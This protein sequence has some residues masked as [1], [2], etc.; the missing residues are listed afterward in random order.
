MVVHHIGIVPKGIKGFI[1]GRGWEEYLSRVK[2]RGCFLGGVLPC[3]SKFLGMFSRFGECGST[4][5]FVHI[6]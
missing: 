6:L 1:L 4:G 5:S 3:Q 2:G